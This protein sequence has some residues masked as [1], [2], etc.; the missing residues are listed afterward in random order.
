MSWSYLGAVP[1]SKSIFNRLLLVQSYNPHFR[2]IGSSSAQ[3]VVLMQKA[4]QSVLK[5]EREI[6]CGLAGTVFRFM[7]L[8]CA[9]AGGEWLLKVAPSLRQRPH[10]DLVQILRQL[11]CESEW[12]DEGLTLRSN[13]WRV[14]GD[15][16]HVSAEKSSQFITSVLLN[17]WKLER[18][19]Y[20]SIRNLQASKS[21][22]NMSMRLAEN[23]GLRFELQNHELTILPSELNQTEYRV[24]PDMSSAFSLAAVAAVSGEAK[25]LQFP[26]NS[27]QPDAVFPSLLA[28]M[29]V[30]CSVEKSVLHVRRASNLRG[31]EVDLSQAPDLFPSLATLCAL[32]EG[33]TILKGAPQL[34]YKE[35]NRIA[36]VMELLKPLGRELKARPDG[37]EIHGAKRPPQ[38]VSPWTF[39]PAHDHRLA[40]AAAVLMQAG[41]SVRVT[42]PEVVEKSF[43]D[44]WS[45]I[46][47]S[48]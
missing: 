23:L 45:S 30:P 48:A 8:R 6:D 22:F 7:T 43:P 21:Y 41:Y 31:L 46:G 20:V 44:F 33:S 25:I 5:G 47:V 27:L 26:E 4:V 24:E 36:K 28:Q 11:S 37:L 14:Q 2:P 32:A 3:D 42:N 12:S 40:M 35:S 1:A 15:A 19:L 13:G 16:L 18:P 38:S 29:G 34:V 17:S 39:D 10:E 9:R